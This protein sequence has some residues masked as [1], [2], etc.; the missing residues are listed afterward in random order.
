MKHMADRDDE[1]T[2]CS[3]LQGPT[4]EALVD[5]NA[6][7]ET[8]LEEE[9]LELSSVESKRSK[10]SL[11]RLDN[12]EDLVSYFKKTTVD[13]LKKL[14]L[15][16]AGQ[17]GRI[18]ER[19]TELSHAAAGGRSTSSI[20]QDMDL[21]EDDFKTQSSAVGGPFDGSVKSEPGF[22][23]RTA[24]FYNSRPRMVSIYWVDFRGS[25]VHYVDVHPRHHG[26]VKTFQRH[27]WIVREKYDNA[28]VSQYVVGDEDTSTQRFTIA[29]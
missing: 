16:V 7:M 13:D 20:V 18:Q 25:E 5:P 11:I 9:S 4:C 29:P 14:G 6:P 26:V 27:V 21:T 24:I 23:R 3:S 10:V 1:E 17:M 28:F 12:I 15:D 22:P 8:S 19:L 2:T